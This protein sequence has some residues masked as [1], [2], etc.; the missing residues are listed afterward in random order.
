MGSFPAG[1]LVSG[2]G[3][4]WFG[5]AEAPT[6]TLVTY[7]TTIS[8]QD[9]STSALAGTLPGEVTGLAAA[10]AALHSFFFSH[11]DSLLGIPVELPAPTHRIEGN[12]THIALGTIAGAAHGKH[13]ERD[14]AYYSRRAYESG[15]CV[16]VLMYVGGVE[17][18]RV[19]D[20]P[21]PQR[22]RFLNNSIPPTY[23]KILVVDT[24][25]YAK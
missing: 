24:Y 4:L 25:T 3:F 17:Y 10:A 20:E 13:K 7:D 12:Y 15:F 14:I 16:F 6:S 1:F 18:C 23:I 21:S 5:I 2:H 8:H 11:G 19:I 22:G 9:V